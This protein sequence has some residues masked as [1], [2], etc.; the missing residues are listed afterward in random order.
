MKENYKYLYLHG[1][2]S[3]IRSQKALFFHKKYAENGIDLEIVNFNKPDF[4]NLTL[5]R[6]IEQ[7]KAIISNHPE[8][9]FVLIGSS[10]GGLTANWIAYQYFQE[11]LDIIKKLILLAPAL[12]FSKS[13][14]PKLTSET[15]KIWEQEGF[16]PVYHYGEKK[17][18]LLSYNFWQ[19][20]ITYDDLIINHD[21]PTLIF[22]GKQDDTIPIE[23][24]RE[25]AENRPHVTLI[26]LDSDH[27]LNDRLEEIWSMDFL[28]NK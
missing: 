14:L 16:L 15:L 22:H 27:S 1:F 6:Q 21:I 7:V 3:S 8:Y 24:S 13:W 25:Y 17:E 11:K 19:D 23:V 4:T 9:K 12:N 10:F 5:S 18:L 26:E 28:E 20:L 2:A